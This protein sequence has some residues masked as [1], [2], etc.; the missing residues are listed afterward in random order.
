MMIGW[1]FICLLFMVKGT[2]SCSTQY[3]F[4]LRPWHWLTS[5]HQAAFFVLRCA[6]WLIAI[7]VW[8]DYTGRQQLSSDIYVHVHTI[9]S[10]EATWLRDLEYC[11]NYVSCAD[12]SV[13]CYL[14]HIC[15]HRQSLGLSGMSSALRHVW[16][17]SVQSYYGYMLL[18]EF[19]SCVVLSMLSC[20]KCQ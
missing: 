17:W 3:P 10:I 2:S 8:H 9:T 19:W 6:Y 15:S 18:H 5:F 4:Y 13:E 12:H 7:F 11:N 14:A 16:V 20:H 1:C